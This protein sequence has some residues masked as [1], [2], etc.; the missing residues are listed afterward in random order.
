MRELPIPSGKYQIGFYDDILTLKYKGQERTVGYR[1]FYPAVNVSGI[2]VNYIKDEKML[3]CMG[4]EDSPNYDLMKE[5]LDY[6]THCYE[7]A[8]IAQSEKTFD[9]VLYG[10]PHGGHAWNNL[11]QIEELVSLGYVVV[12]IGHPGECC[13]TII[14]DKRIGTDPKIFETPYKEFEEYFAKTEN[15]DVSTWDAPIVED[16]LRYCVGMGERLDI[17]CFDSIAVMNEF[18]RLNGD[19]TS[20]FYRKL[21]CSG[22]GM[23]GHSFGGA[24]SMQTSLYDKR[25]KAGINI[26]GWL[27]G[28]KLCDNKVTAPL[29]MITRY[30]KPLVGNFGTH[31]DTIEAIIIPNSSHNMYSDHGFIAEE[32]ANKWDLVPCNMSGEE[33]SKIITECIVAFFNSNMRG[34]NS[35]SIKDISYRYSEESFYI[36]TI[37]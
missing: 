25:I 14:G 13:C 28:A 34:D 20:R 12:G 24:T 7:N 17:W 1:V 31:N 8:Q 29:L 4:E 30:D 5:Y 10:P 32:I 36:G 23:F 33:L 9:V 2:P 16:Y 3:H 6:P 15:K 19:I 18:E 22:F 37:K 21:D 27:F 11:I 26:D 35:V